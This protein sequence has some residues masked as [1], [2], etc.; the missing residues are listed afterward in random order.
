MD[1]DDNPELCIDG[2]NELSA[3][4][5]PLVVIL[6]S[7]LL[8]FVMQAKKDKSNRQS[9]HGTVAEAGL[10]LKRRSGDKAGVS[11]IN[12]CSKWFEHI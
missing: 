12:G 6:I 2:L 10:T 8:R 11:P 1:S 9:R 5:L 4:S 7:A 3:N